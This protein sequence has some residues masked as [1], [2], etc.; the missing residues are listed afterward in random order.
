MHLSD[1]IAEFSHSNTNYSI[2]KKRIYSQTYPKNY[3]IYNL[4]STTVHKIVGSCCTESIK[5]MLQMQAAWQIT[6]Q[7]I[8]QRMI[9]L[10]N[11]V[12][13]RALLPETRDTLIA[14]FLPLMTTNKIQEF[15]LLLK[16]TEEAVTQ[17][18]SIYIYQYL[19]IFHYEII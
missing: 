9:K 3:K 5:Q 16:S 19:H 18:V 4:L 11:A 10:E 17:F 12:K 7:D 8:K 6:L 13:N 2:E 14:H 1:P 15:D